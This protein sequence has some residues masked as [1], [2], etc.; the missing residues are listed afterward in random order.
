VRALLD[1]NVLIALLD[2]HHLHHGQ[3]TQ[4][5]EQHIDRGWASCPITQNGCVRI[6]SHPAYPNRAPA[7]VVAE[8]LALACAHHAHEFWADDIS[9]LKPGA[10]DW[11]RLVAGRHLTDAYLLTLAVMHRGCFVTLDRNIPVAAVPNASAANLVVID[12]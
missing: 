2:A 1:V 12:A 8:R 5:M 10:L 4:W 11:Q 6:V 3:A 9:V 7:Q